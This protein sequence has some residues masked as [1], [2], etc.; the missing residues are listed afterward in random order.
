MGELV[1]LA[2]SDPFN[3]SL[4]EELCT[5][6]GIELVTASNGSGVLEVIARQRP[7]LIVLDAALRTDDGADVLEVL[8]SDPALAHIPILL[9]TG[10]ADEDVRRDGLARGA[11][12]FVTRPYRVFEVERRIR[13]LL[14]LAA[15]EDEAERARSGLSTPSV[16]GTDPLTHA[17]GAGQLRITLSYEA[18]RAVRYGHALTCLVLRVINLTEIVERSGEDT[19]VGL[20]VQ[21]ASNLRRAIRSIDHLFRSDTDEFVLLLPE[22]DRAHAQVVIDRLHGEARTGALT[23]AAI[24]PPPALSLGAAAIEAGSEVV[25]GVTLLHAARGALTPLRFDD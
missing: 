21:L 4:L 8:Q 13:N 19:G 11:A 17:G 7:S 9:A 2:D 23:G 22:T 16:E 25:D 24:D 18:T 12:D 20:V 6:A 14:R 5:E 1:L 15:A 3:L 10:A